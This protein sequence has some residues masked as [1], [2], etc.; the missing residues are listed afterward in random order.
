MNI[1]VTLKLRKTWLL[2]LLQNQESKINRNFTTIIKTISDPIKIQTGYWQWINNV[3]LDGRMN[4]LHKND[5]SAPQITKKMYNTKLSMYEL[6]FPLQSKWASIWIRLQT[7]CLFCLIF[8]SCLNIAAYNVLK[9]FYAF[10][11]V[12][13]RDQ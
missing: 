2:N 4:Y 5:T 9:H 13:W 3:S 1:S 10:L 6:W 11:T 12:N 8:S 7:F